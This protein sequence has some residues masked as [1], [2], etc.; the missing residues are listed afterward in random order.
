MTTPRTVFSVCGM[1]G[2]RCPIEVE[3]KDDRPRWICGN[4]QALGGALCP[5]GAAGLALL[6]DD[7][8]PRQ[9]LIRT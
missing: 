4:V 5:R 8:R 7:E 9:P 3:L 6:E 2:A 1:C